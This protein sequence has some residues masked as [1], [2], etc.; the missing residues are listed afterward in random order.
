MASMVYKLYTYN[1]HGVG[2]R[3]YKGWGV[4]PDPDYMWTTCVY[5]HT[6]AGNERTKELM[7]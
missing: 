3:I 1:G 7:L 2:T 4:G 6:I 5:I